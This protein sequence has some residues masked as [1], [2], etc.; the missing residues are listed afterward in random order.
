MRVIALVLIV[1]THLTLSTPITITPYTITPIPSNAG[2]FYQNL[3]NVKIYSSYLSLLSFTNL[4]LYNEKFLLVKNMHL[5]SIEL[6]QRCENINGQRIIC[7]KS[8][9]FLEFQIRQIN[10]KIETIAHLT[11]HTTQ[12]SRKKR[13]LINGVSSAL[14]WLFG[15]PDA[16][17][18]QFYSN[19]IKSL[20]S[21][22]RNTLNL[23]Q[24][25]IHVISSA[26]INYNNSIQ[27]FKN[28]ENKLNENIRNFNKFGKTVSDRLNHIVSA[29]S[30]LGHIN[31][32]T[33]LSLELNEE[34]DIII[35]SILFA[36]QNILHPFVI[37]PTNMKNELLQIKLKPN[38]QF[39]LALE[40]DSEF[41][42]YFSI[43]KISVV[44]DNTNLIFAIRI[45]LIKT[46]SF[47]LYKLI[48]LPA[49]SNQSVFS[50]IDPTSPFLMLSIT[51]THYGQI[52]DI[53]SCLELPHSNFLCPKPTIFLTT[54]RPICE[55]ILRTQSVN[56]I[57]DDC[58]TRS[59]KAEMEVWHQLTPNQW[60][61]VISDP[62]PATVSCD[63]NVESIMDITLQGTGI[64]E[65]RTSCKA[66]TMTT[67]LTASSNASLIFIN[68][69]PSINITLDDCCIENQQLLQASPMSPIHIDNANLDDLR[70]A[71]HKLDQFDEI[72]R[73]EINKPLL[74]EQYTTF[75]LI[76]G[77]ITVAL[78]IFV[79]CYCC[80]RYCCNCTWIP[81]IGRYLPNRITDGTSPATSNSASQENIPLEPV[82][83]PT[84]SNPYNLRPRRST[85][86]D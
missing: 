27:S 58:R 2:I 78:I 19:A 43:S 40:N 24:Q 62:V 31:F 75:G 81:L 55:V 9:Q 51:K 70:H 15:T 16:N 7:K 25:Q 12:T 34:Y 73:K 54:Q 22:N 38:V 69:V 3:G 30:T 77:V 50:Y 17:D 6:C 10:Q 46:Q 56:Q 18:A 59:I 71:K 60:L 84:I 32:L 52:K 45:P 63:P 37:T 85:I 83:Q 49:K 8:L 65:L 76:I 66:Y 14:K 41:H 68:Y 4:T 86:S 23:M 5:K 13:G 48:P 35:A 39:P 21:K 26:I 57:P 47:T 80:S 11:D 53:S 36:K 28:N 29:Q 44:Y 1:A 64:L 74:V 42:N 61:Y 82:A 79:F 33:E 20:Q 72:L 67:S